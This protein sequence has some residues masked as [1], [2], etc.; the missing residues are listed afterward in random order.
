[1][2]AQTHVPCLVASSLITYGTSVF[3]SNLIKAAAFSLCLVG[4]SSSTTLARE[5][6]P[7]EQ[8]V[9]SNLQACIDIVRRHD[10]SEFDY[11]VLET[12]FGRFGPAGKRALFS[13]L[14]SDAGHADIAQLIAGLGPLTPADRQRIKTNWSLEKAGAY[15]PLFLDGHPMSRDFLLLSLGDQ[16]TDVR[17]QARIALIRLPELAK[18]APLPQSI[19]QPLL[20]AL[21]LDP[22]AEGAPYLA[23]L[24][25]A[26]TEVQFAEL[27]RSGDAEIVTASYSS[28][29]RNNPAQAFNLL[30]SE[31][32]QIERPDQVYAVGQMLARRHKSRK[33]GFYQKFSQDISGDSNLPIAARASGLH[34]ILTIAD[35]PFPDVTR[36][37]VEAFNFL[38]S[39]NPFVV[40]DQ[41]LPYLKNDEAH[42]A[43][44]LVWE[45]AQNEKWINRDRIAEFYAGHPLNDSI[46][47]ALLQSDDWRSFSAGLQRAKPVHERLVR[48][49]ID[50][51][52]NRIASAAR[53]HLRLSASAKR[54]EKCLID[55]FDLEDVRAQMPFFESGWMVAQNNARVALK[56]SHLTTA[57]PSSTGWLA[58]YDLAKS[59]LRSTYDGGSI[60]NYDNKSG[61]FERIGI[62][63]GPLGIL[64]AL[65]LQ[66]GQTTNQFWVV[67]AWGGDALDVSV[68]TLDISGAAPRISNVSALPLMARDFSLA[69]NGDLL[70]TFDDPDQMPIR[71]S[72]TGQMSSACSALR[73]SNAIRALQ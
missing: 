22:V 13:T 18:R 70:I 36:E 5:L 73:P 54:N 53:Q 16:N 46:T 49:Q 67:D 42:A 44:R 69:A 62:F 24:N 60:L 33:D 29:Y 34:A 17:E 45:T 3:A 2:S 61:A 1:M 25:S 6:S 72:K 59:G 58:G 28:L 66:L 52:V 65:P 71:L 39:G 47:T 27:L 19:K 31:M 56:R 26:G 50:H 68:Y 43:M 15:L 51:P 9:C 7:Q 8:I 20:K 63:Q 35:G 37:R 21:L 41:Y 32:K 4:M 48:T 57:H 64:P 55:P 38:I 40:Q 14:E 11:D 10:G 30:L 23:R 12:E